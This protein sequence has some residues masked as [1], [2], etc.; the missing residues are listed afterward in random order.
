MTPD[1]P[2]FLVAC[3]CAAWCG[4]CRDYAAGFHALAERF[5]DTRFLWLDVE[6]EADLLD[7]YEVDNFPTLLI[8]RHDAVLFFGPMLPHH[9]LLQRTIESFHAQSPDESRRYATSSPERSAWQT[10]RN[11]RRTLAGQNN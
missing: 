7:D 8:Q 2:E 11:L 10:E 1:Q 6:D 4:T 3:L 9:D 5:P